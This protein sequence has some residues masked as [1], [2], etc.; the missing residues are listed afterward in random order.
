LTFAPDLRPAGGKHG[1]LE[2]GHA[3]W[4]AQ[5][6]FDQNV[7]RATIIPVRGADALSQL[8]GTTRAS[9]PNFRVD[10]GTILGVLLIS[11]KIDA[12]GLMAPIKHDDNG[13]W[14]CMHCAPRW[15][16]WDQGSASTFHQ[17]PRQ[18][19]EPAAPGFRH[20]G[21]LHAFV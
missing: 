16:A 20:S 14:Q 9:R 13:A 21:E 1:R 4:Q 2:I 15:I 7:S 12:L 11:R 5:V 3:W 6:R 10:G 18:W 19:P 8:S 17:N